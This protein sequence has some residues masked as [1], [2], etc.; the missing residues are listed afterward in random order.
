LA[1]LGFNTLVDWMD[2]P[3]LRALVTALAGLDDF[4][5]FLGAGL[6]SFAAALAG[7]ETAL[8]F[9]A[10][11]MGA[12]LTILVA[13]F[14]GFWVDAF[15][16]TGLTATAFALGFGFW[17]TAFRSL[18]AGGAFLEEPLDLDFDAISR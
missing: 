9:F 1:W 15:L 13:L 2:V 12:C 7:F 8:A 18:D 14:A 10:G 17:A 16:A 11:G 4:W 5:T 6:I 3:F